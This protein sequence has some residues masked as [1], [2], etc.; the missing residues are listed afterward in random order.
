MHEVK[1]MERKLKKKQPT[2]T[3]SIYEHIIS[4]REI[5]LLLYEI[6]ILLLEA[7]GLF[8]THII[9]RWNTQQKEFLF[10]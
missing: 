3:T 2:E 1:W 9:S 7:V 4:Y 8:L 10:S 5:I 6:T